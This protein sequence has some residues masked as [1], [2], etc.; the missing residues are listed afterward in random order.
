M[1][2][3]MFPEKI[4][5]Q[6]SENTP[7]LCKVKEYIE[8]YN[9]LLPGAPVIVGFS[10]G[11]DS[12]ALVFLLHKLGY[13]VTAVHIDH[14]IRGE[15][16]QRDAAFTRDFCRKYAIAYFIEHLDIPAFAKTSNLSL[17]TAA[18]QERYRLLQKYAASLHAPV[19]IAHN[20]ND[21]AE[22]VLMH[23]LRGSGLTGL[24]GMQPVSGNIIR[25]LLTVTREEIENFNKKN[26]LSHITDS[27]NSDITF[28][29]NKYRLC[30]LPQLRTFNPDA[31]A[32]I[33][34]CAEL[35]SGYKE[36]IDITMQQ[37]ARELLSVQEDSVT[38]K[39]TDGLP[40]IV[41]FELI[42]LA[43]SRLKGHP[44]DIERIHTENTAALWHKQAG[45]EI[46]LPGGIIARRGY[47]TI[48]FSYAKEPFAAKFDFIPEKTYPW[49]NG[50]TVSS[51]FV[52]A[53]GKHEACE[54]LDF[55]S[56]GSGL[57][58]RT[59]QSGDFIYPLGAQGKCSLKKYFID[60][61]I[62][63]QQRGEIPLLARGSE[64]LAILG[65]T[66]SSR[67]AVKTTTKNIIKIFQGENL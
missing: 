45:R 10:G 30:L 65:C 31:V 54:F 19:A 56:L 40:D 25:P 41:K 46:H 15:E 24:C 27:T 67:A 57:T 5:G 59:R 6:E 21:Q 32:A 20:K 44:A 34:S 42:R 12:T 43:I 62:P 51:C 28:T 58:L 14:G 48:C 61:K 9:M 4:S 55:D 33:A 23:L 37:Y 13:Q 17:E 7:L 35:L 2:F 49:H 29:R 47:E 11:A 38:L 60:K 22:T 63:Q 39:L 36:L 52:S 18:R 1:S 66:V 16:A 26:N 53:M 64:I 8:K 50:Q 3:Y